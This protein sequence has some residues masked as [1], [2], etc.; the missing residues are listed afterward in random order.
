MQTATAN[1]QLPL[2]I[3]AS[4][5]NKVFINIITFSHNMFVDIRA[6]KKACSLYFKPHGSV[7]MLQT[8]RGGQDYI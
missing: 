5:F 3:H 6:E 2:S 7:V 4:L 1:W 8:S